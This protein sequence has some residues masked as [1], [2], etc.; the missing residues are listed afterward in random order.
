MRTD[1]QVNNANV[2]AGLALSAAIAFPV[3]MTIL[4]R[5]AEEERKHVQV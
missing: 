4:N 3:V 2:I 5:K 1:V